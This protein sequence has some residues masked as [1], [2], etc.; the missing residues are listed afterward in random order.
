[1]SIEGVTAAGIIPRNRGIGTIDVFITNADGDPS[2]NLLKKVKAALDEQREINV[3]IE[4]KPL[5]RIEFNVAV[6]VA[7]KDGWNFSDVKEN[8]RESIEE[9]FGML[10]AGETVYLSAIGEYIEHTEGVKNYSFEYNLM[11]DR[12]TTDDKIF[13]PGMITIVERE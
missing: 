9:Y 11:S 8:C 12:S 13:C 5:Q 2:E 6:Y 7:A 4:V 1:M 10:S 3:D